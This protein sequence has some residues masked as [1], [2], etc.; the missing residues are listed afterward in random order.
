MDKIYINNLEF[1]GYHGVFPEEKKLGQ[2]FQVSVEMSCDT[3]E[4]G[5]I[6]DL[7]KSTHYGLVAE[8]IGKLFLEKS[9]DLIETCAEEIAQMILR[10]YSLIYEVKVTVKKPWAP[11]QMHFENVAVEIIRKRHKVYL[12][13]GSN[14]GDKKENLLKAIENIGKIEDTEVTKVSTILETEPFGVVD[15]DDFLNACLEIKTLLTPQELLKELLGIE[16]KMGRVRIKKWGP[17]IIDIDILLYDKEV[18]EDDNLAVPHP[19]MCERS[20]VLDPL[21]EIAPNIIHPL[22][23]ESIFN[24]K[25][26]L[27]SNLVK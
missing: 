27:D 21:C 25:R 6:G 15:Q 19:W 5:K 22:K 8:D 2:K 11:L 7:T 13:I 16:E 1:I 26:K 24:L 18:I 23:R 9:V 4:A 14:I 17:R 20:F 10:K 12:S 3:R